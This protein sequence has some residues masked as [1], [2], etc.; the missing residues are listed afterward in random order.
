M[1]RIAALF[2]AGLALL[3]Q[4]ASALTL[5]PPGNVVTQAWTLAGSPYLVS[6]DIAVPAGNTLTIEDGVSVQVECFQ[7][8]HAIGSGHKCEQAGPAR[9]ERGR[10]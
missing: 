3:A 9:T 8:Q 5:V 4:A 6:G 7:L 1:I 2:A 10:G